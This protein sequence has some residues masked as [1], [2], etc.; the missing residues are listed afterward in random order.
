MNRKSFISGCGI[1][2]VPSDK[3][4]IKEEHP[5]KKY[6]KPEIKVIDTELDEELEHSSNWYHRQNHGHQHKN[7]DDQD[8]DDENN[9]GWCNNP[10]NNDW[11]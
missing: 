6:V 4:S 11:E 3:S 10:I 7:H 1:I 8:D 2:Y 9:S 5:K